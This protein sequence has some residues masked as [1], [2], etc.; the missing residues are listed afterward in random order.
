MTCT[1]KN[2]S[3]T[4]Y[5]YSPNN[6]QLRSPGQQCAQILYKVEAECHKQENLSK[7]YSDENI[8]YHI[9]IHP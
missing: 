5:S 1:G 3:I 4:K 9:S 7:E 6:T 8:F 2:L